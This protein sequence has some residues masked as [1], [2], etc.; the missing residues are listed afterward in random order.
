MLGDIFVAG[1]TNGDGELDVEEFTAIV[2]QVDPT[3][4]RRE[5]G[6]AP[7]SGVVCQCGGKG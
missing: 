7:A 3:Q 6:A 5:V 4:G 1:D 2:K